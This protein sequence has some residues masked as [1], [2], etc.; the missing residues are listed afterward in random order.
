MIKI[1]L[2]FLITIPIFA[3]TA[4]VI[5][6]S[7]SRD[8][9]LSRSAQ[10]INK[11]LLKNLSLE[12]FP[13]SGVTTEPISKKE[14]IKLSKTL[15]FKSHDILL[16]Y[17]MDP[18]KKRLTSTLYMLNPMRLYCTLSIPVDQTHHQEL[19]NKL[20]Q[21]V[22]NQIKLSEIKPLNQKSVGKNI[23][24]TLE[25][26]TKNIPVVE[27]KIT[28]LPIAGKLLIERAPFSHKGIPGQRL[29]AKRK[30]GNQM[31]TQGELYIRLFPNYQLHGS[32]FPKNVGSFE[33]GDHISSRWYKP[34]IAIGKIADMRNSRKIITSE[35]I[36]YITTH[37][38]TTIRW[39]QKKPGVIEQLYKITPYT[40]HQTL[41]KLYTLGI[42]YLV[43]GSLKNNPSG[44]NGVKGIIILNVWS[45]Y[46]GKRISQKVQKISF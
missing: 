15:L 8:D 42:D 38:S 24:T 23:F 32:Y 7:Y 17:H 3:T 13:Y 28:A 27:G 34:V 36:K 45:T 25:K 18:Q 19:L 20:V 2:I 31:V 33:V 16:F 46:T 30:I 4:K 1:L 44:H 10:Q 39:G 21:E 12:K 35:I 11:K 37:H 43:D 26:I 9:L 6:P 5:T 29:T 22:K 14:L 41:R 40:Q